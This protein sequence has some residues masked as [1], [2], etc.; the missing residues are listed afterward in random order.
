MLYGLG[1]F[2]IFV[3]LSDDECC[4]IFFF[5]DTHCRSDRLISSIVRGFAPA[6]S[7]GSLST[8]LSGR[9]V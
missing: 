3:A 8:T 4:F 7:L 5:F 1:I 9:Q 2:Q 6:L